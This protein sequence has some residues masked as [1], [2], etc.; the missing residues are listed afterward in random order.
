MIKHT[1]KQFIV[2]DY[3]TKQGLHVRNVSLNASLKPFHLSVLKAPIFLE[4]NCTSDVLELK[5][6]LM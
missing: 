5:K 4:G 3:D 1:K 6:T 2:C